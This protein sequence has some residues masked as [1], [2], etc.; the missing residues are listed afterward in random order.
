MRP[1]LGDDRAGAGQR[2]EMAFGCRRVVQ[3]AQCDEAGEEFGV[4]ARFIAGL[5]MRG[6]DG[7][8]GFRVAV[9]QQF[10]RQQVA[11]RPECGEVAG[12]G[13]VRRAARRPLGT[14]G[15]AQDAGTVEGQARIGL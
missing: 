13:G 15:V 2:P 6:D 12:V 7:V 8:G 10:A 3:H 9:V 4:G 1:A 5:A 11:F 14:V